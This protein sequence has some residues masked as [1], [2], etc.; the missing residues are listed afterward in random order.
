MHGFLEEVRLRPGMWVRRSSLRHLESILLGYRVALG[1]HGIE[2]PFDFWSP[3][4]RGAF[5]EWLWSRPGM[6]D[7]SALGWAAEI[8]RAA[9]Q[10][11]RPA[12]EMFFELWDQ[13]RATHH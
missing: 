8:E 13:F 5:E 2:E 7:A 11:D 3:G 6:P 10:A 9:E 12:M 1:I 4:S